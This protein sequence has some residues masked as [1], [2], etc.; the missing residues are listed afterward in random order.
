MLVINFHLIPI[1][2]Y[3]IKFNFNDFD[4]RNLIIHLLYRL[5]ISLYYTQFSFTYQQ[6]S[7]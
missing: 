3:Q 1:L 4:K 6:Y 7:L 5:D 2:K